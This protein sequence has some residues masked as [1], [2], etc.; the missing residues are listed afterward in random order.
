MTTSNELARLRK[1]FAA[2]GAAP[3]PEA[4]PPSDRIWLAVRGELP[5]AELRGILDHVATCSACAEDWRI[6]MAFEE[7]SRATGATAAPAAPS[8]FGMRA[9]RPFLVA[10]AL[11]VATV[12][13]YQVYQPKA[14]VQVAGY[15]GDATTV[16]SLVP[17][18]AS[19]PRGRF[20]LSWKTVPGT[21]SYRLTLTEPSTL[22]ILHEKE[23]IT[24]TSYRVPESA[25]AA[26]PSGAKLFWQVIPTFP[27]GSQPQEPAFPVRVQ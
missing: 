22:K 7:E 11:V 27:D 4:C 16:E 9:L 23:G 1:A 14:P 6:A 17:K 19:K 2:P 25:L 21:V 3:Q 10:A 5:P 13:G 20:V 24:S 18:N 15:R 12:T 8:R 26:V